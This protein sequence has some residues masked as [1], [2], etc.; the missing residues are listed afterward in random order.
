M[1]RRRMNR[2]VLV[3]AATGLCLLPTAPAL[4]DAWGKW[5]GSV[6]GQVSGSFRK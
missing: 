2:T 4:A 3:A 5:W 1:N 6:T